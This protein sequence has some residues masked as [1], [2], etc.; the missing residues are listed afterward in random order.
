MINTTH[1]KGSR[2]RLAKCSIRATWLAIRF[3]PLTH[4]PLILPGV[5]PLASFF[6]LRKLKHLG[7]SNCNVTSSDKGLV[8]H[9][10][11]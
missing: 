6:I 4:F 11:R 2:E 3:L 8:V 7:Y 5:H 1:N 9:A 10:H